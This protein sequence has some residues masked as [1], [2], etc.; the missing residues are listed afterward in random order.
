MSSSRNP[1]IVSIRRDA[2]V[3]QS[4]RELN[5]TWNQ[6]Q[7]P[8]ADFTR[9]WNQL[10]Q[11]WWTAA[12]AVHTSGQHTSARH[13]VLDWPAFIREHLS[14]ADLVTYLGRVFRIAHDAAKHKPESAG[15]L[16]NA[17]LALGLT[18]NIE[19]HLELDQEVCTSTGTLKAL[20]SLRRS[21][22]H[23]A[24]D[25]EDIRTK[26]R[27]HML[28]R[29][30]GSPGP[31][32]VTPMPTLRDVNQ[33]ITALR[34]KAVPRAAPKSKKRKA[35]SDDAGDDS[36]E[37]S[38]RSS[39]RPRTEISEE[40]LEEMGQ[41]FLESIREDGRPSLLSRFLD[42][43]IMT[44][45]DIFAYAPPE[46]SALPD[47]KPD[48]T[49]DQLQAHA[50]QADRDKEAQ[51]D[52]VVKEQLELCS[53]L[54]QMGTPGEAAAGDP[55][56]QGLLQALNMSAKNLLCVAR[57]KHTSAHLE[58]RKRKREEEEEELDLDE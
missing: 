12:L 18:D 27:D 33:A 38:R 49:E 21:T 17:A 47:L 46:S 24:V 34:A 1:V 48:A 44:N 16:R 40:D 19:L 39:K 14:A 4:L 26:I 42:E 56:V 35:A 11:D 30:F 13:H 58:S 36:S 7:L 53:R 2:K 15:R 54:V 8:E 29:V 41:S 22:A 37:V 23:E 51:D 28:A 6:A 25:P 45:G 5:E 50:A 43:D 57:D 52:A 32:V 31:Y 3:D 20:S 55:L 9:V 10:H